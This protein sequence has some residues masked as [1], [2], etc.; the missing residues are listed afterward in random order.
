VDFY[1]LASEHEDPKIMIE[2]KDHLRHLHMANPQGRVFPL[3]GT[4][5]TMRRSSPRS[6]PSATRDV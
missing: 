4:S 6:A 5:S 2:A 3:A 1:H